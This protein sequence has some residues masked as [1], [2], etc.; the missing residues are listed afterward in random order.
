MNSCFNDRKGK[1]FCIV[2]WPAM[3]SGYIMIT[4][5]VEDRGVSPTI[6]QH[7]WQTWI[8]MVRSFYSAFGAIKWVYFIMSCSNRLK[9]SWGIVIDSNWCT[10]ADH[11]RKKR[12]LYGSRHD[13]VILQHN[14][15]IPHVAK[16][17]KTYMEMLKWEVWHDSLYSPDVALSDYHLFRSL[18]HDLAEQHFH[19]Y[20]DAKK[21]V[22]SWSA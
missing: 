16:R 4:Q 21:W 18:T 11:L 1:V 10:W 7:W 9:P 3:K 13:K 20:K 12:P 5:S 6:H 14:N 17:R 2:S 15:A 19:S 22:D 8:S